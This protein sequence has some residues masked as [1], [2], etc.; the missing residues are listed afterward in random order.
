MPIMQAGYKRKNTAHVIISVEDGS[1]FLGLKQ[2]ASGTCNSVLLQRGQHAGRAHLLALHTGLES[3]KLLK[4]R[5]LLDVLVG[6]GDTFGVRASL[7]WTLG[8]LLKQ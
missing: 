1:T 6:A 4:T 7:C 2:G 3:K 5:V 8:N